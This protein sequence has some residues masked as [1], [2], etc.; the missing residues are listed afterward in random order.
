MIKVFLFAGTTEGRRLAKRLGA[1]DIPV[2]VSVATEYGAL[3]LEEAG[4]GASVT[5]L[6]GRMTEEEM[7]EK[8]R[9]TAPFIV[10]DAT[11]PYALAASENIRNAAEKAGVPCLRLKRRTKDAPSQKVFMFQELEKLIA[12]LKKTTGNILLTTGVNTLKDFADE[13][14]KSRLFVRVLPGTESLTACEEAGIRGRQIIAMQGP[15]TQEMNRATIHSYEI[16]HLVTKQS[17]RSGGFEEKIFAAQETETAVYILGAPEEEGF[18]YGEVLDRL[19]ELLSVDLRDTVTITFSLVGVGPGDRAFLTE[20]GRRTIEEADVLF[21]AARM[22]EPYKNTKQVF[23]YYQGEEILPRL[24][25]LLREARQKDPHVRAAVLL[26]GD[27]GFY[28]GSAGLIF[29]LSNWRRR[30]LLSD[31]GRFS[32]QIRTIPGISSVQMLAARL[33]ERW[34]TAYIDSLHGEGDE[35]FARV[36][37][38]LPRTKRTFLLTSGSGDVKRLLTWI[39]QQGGHRPRYSLYAGYRLSYSDEVIFGEEGDRPGLGT[40]DAKVTP[41]PDI[42]PEGLYTVMIR[43]SEPESEERDTEGEVQDTLG[44]QNEA[45]LQKPG[46]PITKEEIRTIAI[47]KLRIHE[48]AVVY[49]IG[50]GTGSFAVELGR[51]LRDSRIFAI[52][53][54]PERAELIRKNVKHLKAASVAVVEGEAPDILDTL[55]PPTH[56]VIGGSDGKLLSILQSLFLI[57]PECRVVVMATTLETKA[58][59]TSLLS[60][61]LPVDYELA[62]PEYVEINLSRSRQLGKYR[63]LKAENPVAILAFRFSRKPGA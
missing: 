15:F 56:A 4:L 22:V 52:E 33:Q 45:F 59:I 30:M 53:K 5:V 8:L 51:V 46:I 35:A 1:A 3:V 2:M 6:R 18:S 19:G 40:E 54:E 39:R 34:D 49:D 31:E 41:F 48:P 61:Q 20:E 14:L 60:G 16:R 32:M 44:I 38:E 24:E 17:G 43:N 63:S 11:H 50:S 23:P 29:Y 7:T 62:D 47:S 21:G 10:V 25:Q 9:E 42:I 27:S 13:E 58:E 36:I 12:A 28:S 55:T 57:S 26:S 37:R